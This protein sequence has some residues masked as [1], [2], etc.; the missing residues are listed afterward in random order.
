[1][2]IHFLTSTVFTAPSARA[3]LKLR[4]EL[5]FSLANARVCFL[6][7]QETLSTYSESAGDIKSTNHIAPIGPVDCNSLNDSR[8]YDALYLLQAYLQ[9]TMVFGGKSMASASVI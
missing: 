1:M 7:E 6:D 8:F 3:L 5:S 2:D 9:R 4:H